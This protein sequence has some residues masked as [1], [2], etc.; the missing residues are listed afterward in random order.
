MWSPPDEDHVTIGGG[1][2]QE[3]FFS[4]F[5]EAMVKVNLVQLSQVIQAGM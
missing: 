1:M 2:Y 5:G 4:A 3:D